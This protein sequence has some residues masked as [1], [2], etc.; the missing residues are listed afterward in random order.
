MFE[1]VNLSELTIDP[2]QSIGQEW[3]LITAGNE[4]KCN[5]MTASWGA[6]GYMWNKNVSILF[7][8]PQRYTMEFLDKEDY[9][10]LCFFES[11]YKKALSFCGAHSGRDCDKFQE[12]GL[13]PVFSEKAPYLEQAK[14]VLVCRK[15]SCQRME[16]GSLIDPTIDN[17]WYEEKDYHN[18]MIGEIVKVLVKK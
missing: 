16:P 10:T 13:T 8:R 14:L 11:E 5:T 17:T 4:E 3:M 12:T 2:F 6:L 1:E 9:Y 18:F 15:M 7:V